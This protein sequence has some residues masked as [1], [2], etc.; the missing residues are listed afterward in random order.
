M[1]Y[2]RLGRTGLKV[3]PVCLG[4]MIFGS[5]TDQ[6]GA[7]RIIA[8]G[9]EHG[10]NFIDTSNVYTRGRSEEIIGT[11]LK[12]SRD[13]WVLATKTRGQTGPGPNDQGLSRKQIM[14]SVE[15]SLA[16][17]GTDYIDVLYMHR[18]DEE[19][20]LEESVRAMADLVHQGKIRYFGVSNFS[21]WRIAEVCKLCDELNIDRPA[22]NSPLYNIVNREAEVE[23]LPA[24]SYYGVGVVSYSPLARGVLSGIYAPGVAPDPDTR[25]GRGDKRLLQNE[26]RSESLEIAQKLKAHAEARG[27]TLGQFAVAWILHNQL[28]TSVIAGPENEEQ[29]RNYIGALDYKFQPEDE[30]LVDSLVAVGSSSTLGHHD[31]YYPIEGR[32]PRATAP[33]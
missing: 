27:I 2:R 25:A 32:Q 20:P 4:T 6:A 29:W 17:L 24:C 33:A 22:A 3:S 12:G 8:V 16:R 5:D 11:A 28:M 13:R 7:E 18:Q 26:W 19:T 21:S 31:P 14:K 30:A 10:M 9:A 15:G 23:Q 1:Q